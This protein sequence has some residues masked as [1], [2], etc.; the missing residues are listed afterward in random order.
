MIQL[1]HV[2]YVVNDIELFSSSLPH[3]EFEKKVHDPIQ[4]AVLA[5]YRLGNL[6]RIELIQPLNEASFTWAHLQKFGS[7]LHHVCYEGIPKNDIEY[8]LK[9]YRLMRVRGPM[10]AKLFD[11][12]VIFAINR[13]RSVLEFLL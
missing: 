7:S 2:G 12:E 11:R 10:Y 1:H 5:V 9:Q 8:F 13:Q 4:N 3:L 6:S